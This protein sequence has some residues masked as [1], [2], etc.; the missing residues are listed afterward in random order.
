MPTVKGVTSNTITIVT[1]GS[2]GLGRNTVL[3]LAKRGVHAI[4]TYNSNRAEAEKVA[5]LVGKTG[6]KA[7][8]LKSTR[9]IPVTRPPI[10][11]GGEGVRQSHREQRRLSVWRFCRTMV[12]LEASSTRAT[13]S[14]GRARL[15]VGRF[16]IS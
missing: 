7:P 15:P 16:P 12:P 9:P 10:S 2:R 5:G 6:Q 3:S 4:F 13:R 8:A 14:R 11:T 1:G